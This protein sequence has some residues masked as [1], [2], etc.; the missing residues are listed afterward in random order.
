R[1]RPERL[2]PTT[3]QP[4]G[5]MRKVALLSVAAL[6]CVAATVAFAQVT[7]ENTYSVQGKVSPNTS[8][9]PVGVT[10]NYQVGEKNGNRPSAVSR[11][12]IGFYGITENGGLFPTCTTA[13]IAAAKNDSK[14]PAGALVG[15]GQVISK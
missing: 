1:R 9:G 5:L 14:C 8:N 12:E 15:T 6:V 10:F 2:P 4:G 3:P 13:A 7:Q 11:Y